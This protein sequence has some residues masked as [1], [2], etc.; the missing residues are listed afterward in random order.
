MSS[1][2]PKP[3]HTHR[4]VF[5]T[6]EQALAMVGHEEPP[7]VGD[8][9][10]SEALIRLYCGIS[11]DANPSYWSAD[12][13]RQRWGGVIAPA[14]MLQTW[15]M[16]LCWT[17]ERPERLLPLCIS[18]PLPGDTLINAQQEAEFFEPIRV[19]DR[20]AMRDRVH[21]VSPEKQT[22]LGRGHF[23]T[24][25]ALYERRDG[26]FGAELTNSVFRYRSAA[27]PVP[28]P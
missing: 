2:N 21:A 9:H 25:K 14:G 18:V 26:T 23:V 22:H 3:T 13:A 6:Y 8:I 19:G 20:L 7:R 16:P 28:S 15:C 4:M 12:Y 10:V 1:A 5:G 11:E 24:T 17:P 27:T